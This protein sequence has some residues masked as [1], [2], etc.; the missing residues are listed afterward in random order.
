[1]YINACAQSCTGNGVHDSRQREATS[2]M[3][4]P[5]NILIP[6]PT[7][8]EPPCSTSLRIPIHPI[9]VE[10]AA[11]TNASSAQEIHKKPPEAHSPADFSIK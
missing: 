6:F 1:M 8:Q 9:T 7:R 2:T 11:I 10:I 4:P 3:H 5:T